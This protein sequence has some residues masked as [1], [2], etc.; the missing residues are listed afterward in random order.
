MPKGFTEAEKEIIRGRLLERGRK[1]FIL[2][3]IRKTNVEELTR[4]AGISKGAF[5][6]FFDSKEELFMEI[7]EQFETEFR[8]EI[9]ESL[10]KGYSNP[11]ENFKQVLKA[12][13]AVWKTNPLMQ[14]F[15]QEDYQYLL[16]KLPAERVEKHLQ[17]DDEFVVG[18]VEYLKEQGVQINEDPQVIAGLMQALFYVSMHEKEIGSEMY[19]RTMN[20][21]VELVAD[22]LI[23][24]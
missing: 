21:L 22:H 20:V 2:Y 7:M 23:K 9:I 3:G 14:H 13:F 8:E 1:L 18:M 11:K 17:A 15:S 24:A 10:M 16:R 12:A 4:A 6:V 19:P 5:Y